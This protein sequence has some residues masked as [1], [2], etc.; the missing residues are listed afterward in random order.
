[1]IGNLALNKNDLSAR[2]VRLNSNSTTMIE[3]YLNRRKSSHDEKKCS[4]QLILV[5]INSEWTVIQIMQLILLIICT[6]VFIL[7]IIII[8]IFLL[9]NTCE[10]A[11]SNRKMRIKISMD[12]LKKI[13][14]LWINTCV[15]GNV[16]ND[17]LKEC[18]EVLN[19]LKSILS[20]FK[21][22]NDTTCATLVENLIMIS[23]MVCNNNNNLFM[24][25]YINSNDDCCCDYL[26]CILYKIY[27]KNNEMYC[28]VIRMVM[29]KII[30]ATKMITTIHICARMNIVFIFLVIGKTDGH[31]FILIIY[32]IILILHTILDCIYQVMY[33]FMMENKEKHSNIF[34]ENVFKKNV[35]YLMPRSVLHFFNCRHRKVRMRKWRRKCKDKNGNKNNVQGE[36]F[37]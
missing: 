1:M 21:L 3:H 7:Y 18:P 12:I 25:L 35:I 27:F 6:N 11:M 34:Q 16:L 37:I 2:I 13:D 22:S 24:R 29:R 20:Y 14:S 10:F 36:I 15:N 5:I 19:G 26:I 4:K 23:K 17:N 28:S 31:E 32:S 9:I 30:V 33:Q 8:I